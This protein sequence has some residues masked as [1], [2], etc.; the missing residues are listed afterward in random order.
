MQQPKK[1][2]RHSPTTTPSLA[3][4]PTRTRIEAGQREHRWPASPRQAPLPPG[5][6]HCCSWRLCVDPDSR[7]R[8]S[9][10]PPSARSSGCCS[11]RGAELD[12]Q[13]HRGARGLR[14]ENTLP[15]FEI[16]LDLEVSTLELDLHFSADNQVVVWHDPTIDPDKC[17]LD[18]QAPGRRARS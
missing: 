7:G 4:S 5:Q 13:G 17:R 16:A 18:D 12:I 6:A 3:G 8:D 15:S 9:D 11:G 10:S 2:I 1:P 14:P